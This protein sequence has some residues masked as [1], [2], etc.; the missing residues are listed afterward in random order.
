MN[1]NKNEFDNFLKNQNYTSAMK[2]LKD[3]QRLID[4]YQNDELLFQR[5]QQNTLIMSA[6][7]T[8]QNSEE[9][10]ESDHL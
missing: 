5:K 3:R 4:T 9:V 8:V 10:T 6:F 1:L 7:K 2:M